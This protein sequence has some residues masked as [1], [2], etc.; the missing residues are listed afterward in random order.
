MID[1]YEDDPDP[2]VTVPKKS[3]NI[4]AIAGGVVGGVVLLTACISAGIFFLVRRRRQK[5]RKE[6][7]V[8]A[9]PI[10]VVNDDELYRVN[11]YTVIE[12]PSIQLPS[13]AQEKSI[14][15]RARRNRDV[16]SRAG[17]DTG[18]QVCQLL[19]ISLA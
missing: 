14:F 5:G 9:I 4:S 3:L 12:S 13:N 19:A 6:N 1:R 11:P 2:E 18:K 15:E 17:I 10:A 8:N 16:T 7:P